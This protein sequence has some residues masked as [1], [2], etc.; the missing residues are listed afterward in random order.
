M[1]GWGRRGRGCCKI[2]ENVATRININNYLVGLDDLP[3]S[4]RT[5]SEFTDSLRVIL[6]GGT[7]HPSLL[8]CNELRS[9]VGGI[10]ITLGI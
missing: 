1:K 7:P 3:R 4:Q 10:Q 2:D 5:P 8:T 9:R 6:A